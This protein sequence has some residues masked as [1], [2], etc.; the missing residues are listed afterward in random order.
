MISVVLQDSLNSQLTQEIHKR[1]YQ[2]FVQELGWPLRHH[3]EQEIDEFDGIGGSIL[4]AGDP[5][6]FTMR[7]LPK[8]I[9]M[10]AKLWPEFI[11]LCPDNGVELSRWVS[12]RKTPL[13]ETRSLI[14][15]LIEEVRSWDTP[16]VFS[17]ATT[18]IARS[19]SIFGMNPTRQYQMG[20][21][22]F[23]CVWEF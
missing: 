17:V 21:D 19:H 20:E 7:L 10:V 22:M 15:E 12:H 1:R 18:A 13:R 14:A 6:S 23:L 4:L 5:L 11:D 8:S 9:C 3:D 16:S 2:V